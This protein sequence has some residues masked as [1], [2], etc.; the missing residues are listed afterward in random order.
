ML[1]RPGLWV[2]FPAFNQE[3]ND[4]RISGLAYTLYILTCLSS[5]EDKRFKFGYL[6]LVQGTVADA[7][8]SKRR[9]LGVQTMAMFVGEISSNSSVIDSE[10]E[11]RGRYLEGY[12]SRSLAELSSACD[13]ALTSFFPHLPCENKP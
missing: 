12:P 5:G 9:V 8:G 7:S 2:F 6:Q 11:V 10:S 1:L 3:S 13:L 4:V